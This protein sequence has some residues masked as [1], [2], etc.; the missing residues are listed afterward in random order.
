MNIGDTI[1][2]RQLHADGACYR[3][4]HAIVESASPDCIVVVLHIGLPIHQDSGDWPLPFNTRMFFWPNTWYVLEEGY[5]EDGLLKEIYTNINA[6]PVF[7]DD[8]IDYMDYELDVSKEPGLPAV[9]LDEDEFAEA[10][11]TYGYTEQHQQQCWAA[12][13]A[14]LA[15]SESW[16]PRGWQT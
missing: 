11:V 12:V 6:P 3:W 4:H 10:I 8:N 15:L 16:Q 9:V 14:G 13:Q 7:G 1:T 5:A 2:I